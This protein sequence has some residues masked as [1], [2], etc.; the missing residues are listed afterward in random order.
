M[1]WDNPDGWIAVG[2]QESTLKVLKLDSAPSESKENKQVEGAP[3]KP[4]VTSQNLEGHSGRLDQGA[5]RVNIVLGDV[6]HITWNAE[7]SK[8]TT[9]DSLGSIIVWNRHNGAWYAEMMNNRENSKVA[10]VKWDGAGSRVCIG[11]KDGKYSV[12]LFKFTGQGMS[13]LDHSK[14]VDCGARSW[15]SAS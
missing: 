5:W 7:H 1:G 2:A 12:L 11:Y 15:M 4:S 14:E 6:V 8:L 9:A 10:G 13:L 3:A